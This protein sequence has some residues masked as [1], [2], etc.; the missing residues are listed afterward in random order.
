MRSNRIFHQIILNQPV[1]QFFKSTIISF[2]TY[3]IFVVVSIVNFLFKFIYISRS[4][5]PITQSPSS[6]S[7]FLNVWLLFFLNSTSLGSV[8]VL[9]I[10]D[11]KESS[12]AFQYLLRFTRI[13][14]SMAQR[15][16]ASGK[17]SRIICSA[18]GRKSQVPWVTSSWILFPSTGS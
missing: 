15:F 5:S 1:T 12:W 2:I 4:A 18:S 16:S 11:I 8:F 10:S 13:F 3:W 9:V 14:L 17:A 7:F 6:I